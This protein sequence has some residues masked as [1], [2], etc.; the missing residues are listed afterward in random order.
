VQHEINKNEN[1]FLFGFRAYFRSRIIISIILI[2]FPFIYSSG[3]AYKGYVYDRE[4]K[5]PVANANIFF[6]GMYRGTASNADGYFEINDTVPAGIPLIVYALGYYSTA[7]QRL[8]NTLVNVFLEPKIFDIDEV[9]VIGNE[10]KGLFKSPDWSLEKKQK[11]FTREFLGMSF[12]SSK[13]EIMNIEDITLIYNRDTKT[14]MAYTDEPI[15][16]INN[17]LGFE[18]HFFLDQ[19]SSTTRSISYKG[20]YYFNEID[21]LDEKAKKKIMDRRRNT[22]LG[23]RMHLIR[24]LWY[25]ELEKESFRLTEMGI[26]TILSDSI[27]TETDG[28]KYIKIKPGTSNR[29]IKILYTPKASISFLGCRFD[30]AYIQSDGY[31]DPDGIIWSGEI[32]KQRVADLLPFDYDPENE[33]YY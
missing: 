1:P 14:L 3:Q 20:K 24:T 5:L 19:F 15:I 18:V 21:K 25:G 4:S 30:S 8:E 31:F 7:I 32:G 23:S 17:A 16:I 12:N 26:N 6:E 27:I 2:L 29:E 10:K 33:E 28:K 11:A 9:I 22:Y 13:C